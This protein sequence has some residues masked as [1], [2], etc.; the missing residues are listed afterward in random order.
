M[1][2]P[3][4][5]IPT[6][7]TIAAHKKCS[8]LFRAASAANGFLEH[9]KQL[10]RELHEANEKLATAHKTNQSLHRRTQKA[11]KRF[12]RSTMG[13]FRA[14]FFSRHLKWRENALTEAS[15]KAERYR[16]V[17]LKQDAELIELRSA[18][19]LAQTHVDALQKE[20]AD[21]R[22]DSER[23][24]WLEEQGKGQLSPLWAQEWIKIRSA[25]DAARKETT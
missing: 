21:A 22:K 19:S 5:E 14:S 10:E 16:L 2:T 13:G 18:L 15:E 9:A 23:L 8:G 17:T 1:S 11:E 6:P 20:C 24:D 25:I 7:R 3:L 12:L 4:Q